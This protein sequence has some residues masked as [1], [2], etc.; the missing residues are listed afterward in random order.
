MSL[1]QG[2]SKE[3]L[4]SAYDALK[5]LGPRS[6]I[7]SVQTRVLDHQDARGIPVR[8]VRLVQGKVLI[9]QMVITQGNN[10]LILSEFQL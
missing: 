3:D 2:L 7:V 10:H 9:R 8:L 5:G 6:G 1:Y 4:L